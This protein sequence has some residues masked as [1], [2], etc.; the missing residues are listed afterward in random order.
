MKKFCLSTLLGLCLTWLGAQNPNCPAYPKIMRQADSLLQK[1]QYVFALKKLNAAKEY[2][3]DETKKVDAKINEVVAAIEQKRKQA[4]KINLYFQFGKEKAAWAYDF[5]SGKFAVINL[6]GDKLTEFLYDAPEGFKDGVAI[7]KVNNQFVFIQAD[8]KEVEGRYDFLL[9]TVGGMY[10]SQH[11]KSLVFLDKRGRFLFYTREREDFLEIESK[12]RKKGTLNIA[13]KGFIRPLYDALE[14]AS[15]GLYRVNVGGKANDDGYL[16]GGQWGLVDSVGQVLI[17][18]QY[19][20][21]ESASKGLYRVNVGG[22]AN[23]YGYLVGGQ[24][25]LVDSVGNV[26]IKPQ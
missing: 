22:K 3:P 13:G 1:E 18:P 12:E 21:L 15:K 23:D 4:E 26:L 6:K 7:A 17:K 8:G 24:W 25:G 2:C 20:A 11:D 19:D 16:V 9:P 10:M 5:A 14:S